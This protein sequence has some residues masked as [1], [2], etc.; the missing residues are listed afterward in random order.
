MF[1]TSSLTLS[2]VSPLTVDD[3]GTGPLRRFEAELKVIVEYEKQAVQIAREKVK[4]ARAAK[5][6]QR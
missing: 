3:I 6:E 5:E 2:N 4:E 1:S